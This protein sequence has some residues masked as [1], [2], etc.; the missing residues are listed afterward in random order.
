MTKIKKICLGMSSAFG[1]ITIASASVG[2]VAC[3]NENKNDTKPE[4]PNNKPD[5]QNNPEDEKTPS[6]SDQSNSGQDSSSSNSTNENENGSSGEHQSQNESNNSSSKPIEPPKPVVPPKPIVPPAPVKTTI[7]QQQLIQINQDIDTIFDNHNKPITKHDLDSQ[8]AKR[9]LLDA[10]KKSIIKQNIESSLLKEIK[11]IITDAN[12]NQS[13]VK[14]EILFDNNKVAFDSDLDLNLP[15]LT[16]DIPNTQVTKSLKIANQ[17]PVE[18]D[19]QLPWLPVN[20]KPDNSTPDPIE[21][22]GPIPPSF[23][24]RSPLVTSANTKYSKANQFIYDL[25]TPVMFS[26][27]VNGGVILTNGTGWVFDRQQDNPNSKIATYYLATNMHVMNL[28]HDSYQNEKLW[29]VSFYLGNKNIYPAFSASRMQ[30]TDKKPMFKYPYSYYKYDSVY[31]QNTIDQTWYKAQNSYNYDNVKTRDING[32]KVYGRQ[33][34]NSFNWLNF[35]EP[36]DD[37][38]LLDFDLIPVGIKHNFDFGVIKIDVQ[39]DKKQ[40]FPFLENFDKLIA[41]RS[42]GEVYDLS[43]DEQRDTEVNVGGFPCMVDPNYRYATWSS[44]NNEDNFEVSSVKKGYSERGQ[45]AFQ[46]VAGTPSFNEYYGS[47][48]NINLS[49]GASGSMVIDSQTFLIKGIY[50]GGLESVYTKE[51]SGRYVPFSQ[52]NLFQDWVSFLDSMNSKPTFI[53]AGLTKK[54]TNQVDLFASYWNTLSA[55]DKTWI[56]AY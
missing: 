49:H 51:F 35:M 16:V 30:S 29:N 55:Y 41:N 15:D 13:D 56:S 42:L 4:Q 43:Q 48:P 52:N 22:N 37:N 19:K 33:K 46:A 44:W 45:V 5:D 1:L 40:N 36:Y 53:S 39:K 9:Q 27:Q 50:W 25:S 21:S 26:N 3:S 14:I 12:N 18:Y 10:I 17:P 2:L 6:I 34:R 28:W 11:L 31:N 8:D 20:Q 32:I 38:G 54:P 23:E 47:L 7:T 24:S